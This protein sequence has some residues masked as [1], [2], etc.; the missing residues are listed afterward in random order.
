MDK[1]FIYI[2]SQSLS[3]LAFGLATGMLLGLTTPM[4]NVLVFGF[5]CFVPVGAIYSLG[6][7]L[8]FG[9]SVGLNFK[10]TNLLVSELGTTSGLTLIVAINLVLII[11]LTMA[12]QKIKF[13]KKLFKVRIIKL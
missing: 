9:A 6:A 7:G 5:I 3:W 2:K 11:G 10:V 12:T 13:L 4:V 8:F 1:K